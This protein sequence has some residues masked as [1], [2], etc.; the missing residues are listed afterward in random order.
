[1]S[2]TGTEWIHNGCPQQCWEKDI[3]GSG[4]SETDET[5]INKHVDQVNWITYL[6]QYNILDYTFILCI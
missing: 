3:R 1:M 5:Y 2:T 6:L 4:E